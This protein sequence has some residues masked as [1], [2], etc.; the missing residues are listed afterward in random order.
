MRYKTGIIYSTNSIYTINESN[1]TNS[2]AK[3]F[4][5]T[6][7]A[8]NTSLSIDRVTFKSRFLVIKN[9]ILISA[10][11]LFKN[12]IEN[13]IFTSNV[14]FIQEGKNSI[15]LVS[16]EGGSNIFIQN[17]TFIKST[18][19]SALL[20]L[21]NVSPY[22]DNLFFQDN[23]GE[24][25]IQLLPNSAEINIGNLYFYKNSFSSSLISIDN[26]NNSFL[27]NN[28]SIS[29]ITFVKNNQFGNSGSFIEITS[30]YSTIITNVTGMNNLD[31]LSSL[32]E[33]SLL[34]FSNCFLAYV[35]QLTILD[36]FAEI[37]STENSFVYVKKLISKN[38]MNLIFIHLLNSEI[39]F[40]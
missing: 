25:V 26:S 11:V 27:Y 33:I 40:S 31:L 3:F 20:S 19:Q 32:N 39:I 1:F 17:L 7:Y 8:D 35:D 14:A 9:T 15:F 10:V 36:S 34:S 4:S 13:V 23:Q 5:S 24:F 22:M 29:N 16:V 21:N 18:I 38:N 6:V 2:G 37:I 28:F 30:S 12:S